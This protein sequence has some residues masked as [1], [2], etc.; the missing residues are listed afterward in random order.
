MILENLGL[1]IEAPPKGVPGDNFVGG[2]NG[3]KAKGGS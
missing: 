2:W 3:A 1:A